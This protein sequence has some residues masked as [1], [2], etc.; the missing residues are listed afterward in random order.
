[1]LSAAASRRAYPQTHP[2]HSQPG[3]DG[4][5][6][7]P[8]RVLQGADRG[9]APEDG[10]R[11]AELLLLPARLGPG[12][13]QLRQQDARRANAGRH[14]AV[15][16]AGRLHVPRVRA[17]GQS[18]R[19]ADSGP[20]VPAARR[21]HAAHQGA[22]RFRRE[23]RTGTVA[24]GDE[25]GR[26]T[27][28]HAAGHAQQVSGPAG[29]GRAHPHAGGSG[30]DEDHTAQH[31]RVRAGAGRKAGRSGVQVRVALDTEQ[32]VLQDGEEDELVLQLCLGRL[33]RTGPFCCAPYLLLFC[34]PGARKARACDQTH[35][36]MLVCAC[37]SVC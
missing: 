22:G 17:G 9:T 37:V 7:R 33:D 12:I 2:R 13:H 29:S 30:R 18:G 35:L 26:D 20:R 25:R 1:L 10:L 11:S 23:G 8:E 36:C 16:Q 24:G 32:S 5:T 14:P 15:G 6:V 27:V 19:G 31:D 3:R 4:E 34:V 21:P 28:R